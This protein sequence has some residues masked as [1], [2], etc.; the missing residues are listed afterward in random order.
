SIR[1]RSYV[2]TDKARAHALAR[3][4]PKLELSFSPCYSQ[5]DDNSPHGGTVL[6]TIVLALSIIFSFASF[7]QT[8]SDLIIVEP[9]QNLFVG[10]SAKPQGKHELQTVI[11]AMTVPHSGT[12]GVDGGFEFGLTDRFWLGPKG[13]YNV[14]QSPEGNEH[15]WYT[16]AGIGYDII[17]DKWF[18]L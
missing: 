2:T 9:E 5:R 6:R 3:Q 7:S 16:G 10:E 1:S 12:S 4:K 14:L 13:S 8:K 15:E 17:A 11:K 18:L